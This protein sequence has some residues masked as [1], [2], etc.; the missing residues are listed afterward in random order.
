M[1]RAQVEEVAQG[2]SGK[3]AKTAMSPPVERTWSRAFTHATALNRHTP[4]HDVVAD[5]CSQEV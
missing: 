2:C 4:A 1:K 5:A 3:D